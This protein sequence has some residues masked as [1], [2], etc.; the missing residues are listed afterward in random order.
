MLGHYR[1]RQSSNCL[2]TANSTG[3][4]QI[5]LYRYEHPANR[6]LTANVSRLDL[7]LPH[8]V[9]VSDEGSRFLI[10]IENAQRGIYI[11]RE[12]RI[13]AMHSSLYAAWHEFGFLNPPNTSSIRELEMKS[14]LLPVISVQKLEQ[15][16]IFT[17][18]RTL[19]GNEIM[20]ITMEL[21]SSRTDTLL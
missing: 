8:T 12:Y 10:R 7:L 9:F 5:L 20:L 19:Q 18:E 3:S 15:D 11:I 4:F 16:D 14:A 6:Y 2:I 17:I 1:I 21:Y 13:D